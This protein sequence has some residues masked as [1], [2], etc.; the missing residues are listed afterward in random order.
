MRPEI[1]NYPVAARRAFQ[2]A[3][4]ILPFIGSPAKAAS[5]PILGVGATA[6]CSAWLSARRHQ[7]AA[8]DLQNWA[9]GYF[10][11]QEMAMSS[12]FLISSNADTLYTALDTQCQQEPNISIA[13]A[14]DILVAQLKE[15]L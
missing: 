14:I 8:N 15:G 9:L 7:P 6:P 4:A 12:N 3:C 10:S 2:I 1:R 13:S 5:V 11:G